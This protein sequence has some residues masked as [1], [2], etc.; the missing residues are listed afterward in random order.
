MPTV[1]HEQQ[2]LSPSSASGAS[3]SAVGAIS[4]LRLVVLGRGGEG[5][6]GLAVSPERRKEEAKLLKRQWVL[7]RK[8]DVQRGRE[9]A[10]RHLLRESGV[11]LGG[12]RIGGREDD[13]KL[14]QQ[15][16]TRIDVPTPRDRG[17]T[18]VAGAATSVQTLPVIITGPP[19][20]DQHGGGA[21][22]TS[23]GSNQQRMKSRSREKK[24]DRSSSRTGSKMSEPESS[25]YAVSFESH[26]ASGSEEEKGGEPVDLREQELKPAFAG[27]NWTDRLLPSLSGCFGGG[28]AVVGSQ[29]A[30]AGGTTPKSQTVS[31]PK[32][33]ER[34]AGLNI[35]QNPSMS[36]S[37]SHSVA[38]QS[39]GY[40]STGVVQLG[41]QQFIYPSI[42]MEGLHQTMGGFFGAGGTG[43]MGTSCS[44][45]SHPSAGVGGNNLFGGSSKRS[46]V[47]GGQTCAGGADHEAA[48]RELVAAEECGEISIPNPVLEVSTLSSNAHL[49]L[50]DEWMAEVSRVGEKVRTSLSKVSKN[51][52]LALAMDRIS[53]SSLSEENVEILQ[54]G[55]H[56]VVG[57]SPER[58]EVQS[59]Q[60]PRA[61]PAGATSHMFLSSS[62]ASDSR[63]HS[64]SA[65]V[66]E[67]QNGG[68][69]FSPPLPWRQAGS[70]QQH[71]KPPSQHS[72][73][74]VSAPQYV[75][76]LPARSPVHYPVA[77]PVLQHADH[78]LDPASDV[79]TLEERDAS[80]GG[81]YSDSNSVSKRRSA[82]REDTKRFGVEESRFPAAEMTAGVSV[83]RVEKEKPSPSP[84]PLSSPA[85]VS[86]VISNVDSAYPKEPPPATPADFAE[87]WTSPSKTAPSSPAKTESLNWPF[88]NHDPLLEAK[89]TGKVKMFL[90]NFS[91]KPKASPYASSTTGTAMTQKE[92]LER[93]LRQY[94]TEVPR[95]VP[96]VVRELLRVFQ[97]EWLV[98]EA[99]EEFEER[100]L[101]PNNGAA[102]E[103]CVWQAEQGDVW[104]DG[105]V[106]VKDKTRTPTKTPELRPAR[107]FVEYGVAAETDGGS[108]EQDVEKVTVK[109]HE[110]DGE[111]G[112]PTTK[113]RKER[114]KE[115]YYQAK[116]ASVV[117]P[118]TQEEKK[119]A[120]A[121]AKARTSGRK[122][123]LGKKKQLPEVSEYVRTQLQ[124]GNG[125]D[126]RVV[127]RL[128]RG[129]YQSPTKLL[130][131]I[132]AQE[133]LAAGGATH[134]DDEDDVVAMG[135]P[136]GPA[137]QEMNV[138]TV[139]GAQSEG[140]LLEDET[141][142]WTS[143]WLSKKVCGRVGLEELNL[144]EEL[145]ESM[146][147]QREGR[148][149]PRVENTYHHIDQD[150]Q[151]LYDARPVQGG[152]GGQ[153]G[154][155]DCHQQQHPSRVK[156]LS[157]FF[158]NKGFVENNGV[159][160]LYADEVG[161]YNSSKYCDLEAGLGARR[162]VSSEAEVDGQH[163]Q[164][165][166]HGSRGGG[167]SSSSSSASQ[168]GHDERSSDE[169]NPESFPFVR[170]VF[171][172]EFSGASDAIRAADVEQ[173]VF[174]CEQNSDEEEHFFQTCAKM[175]SDLYP[176]D[177]YL[178]GQLEEMVH[179]HSNSKSST[180]RCVFPEQLEA[181]E[182]EKQQAHEQV[183]EVI[184]RDEEEF[185]GSTPK[186]DSYLDRE[187][188]F[189]I[190]PP[191]PDLKVSF[192]PSQ[193]G[194]GV[195]PDEITFGERSD[196]EESGGAAAQDEQE[197]EGVFLYSS[198]PKD[199]VRG[200]SGRGRV[201]DASSSDEVE[202][203]GPSE[204]HAVQSLVTELEKT[205]LQQMYSTTGANVARTSNKK[206]AST[207]SNP[208]SAKKFRPSSRKVVGAAPFVS[209][210]GKVY[211]KVA[212]HFVYATS[213]GK[214]VAI[215]GEAATSPKTDAYVPGA[216]MLHVNQPRDTD[217]WSGGQLQK[218]GEG[219]SYGIKRKESPGEQ[220]GRGLYVDTS[221]WT[222]M[223]N[224]EALGEEEAKVRRSHLHGSAETTRRR[225]PNAAKAKAEGENKDAARGARSS[226]DSPKKRAETKGKGKGAVEN[227]KN[228]TPA[229]AD[230]PAAS[231]R[232]GGSSG[233]TTSDKK[234]GPPTKKRSLSQTNRVGS[235]AIKSGSASAASSAKSSKAKAS[236]T[237]PAPAPPP[238]KPAVVKASSSQ[239][240]A[241]SSSRSPNKEAFPN[242]SNADT[243]AA[244]RP[245]IKT[246]TFILGQHIP[247]RVDV[248][249]TRFFEHYPLPFL[250]VTK[251]RENWYF[252]LDVTSGARAQGK[253]VYVDF[254]GPHHVIVKSSR[255]LESLEAFFAS[256]Y[257]KHAQDFRGS[258]QEARHLD[259]GS[260]LLFT[261]Q[262]E[263]S[264][265]PNS[266]SGKRVHEG[267]GLRLY[268][269][270]GSSPGGRGGATALGGEA[271]VAQ[272]QQQQQLDYA[273]MMSGEAMA[274]TG[275]VPGHLSSV[276]FGAKSRE[277]QEA[278]QSLAMG[279]EHVAQSL[280][281]MQ[282]VASQQLMR[283]SA[284][285]SGKAVGE[286]RR[287]AASGSGERLADPYDPSIAGVVRG[288][289]DAWISEKRRTT[290]QEP[291]LG[292]TSRNPQEFSRFPQLEEEKAVSEPRHSLNVSNK[293]S[294]RTH[295]DARQ[296]DYTFAPGFFNRHHESD[297]SARLTPMRVNEHVYGIGLLA[298]PDVERVD[299]MVNG[300][301]HG[302]GVLRPFAESMEQ[303]GSSCGNKVFPRPLNENY[304][305][306]EEKLHPSPEK[307]PLR[308]HKSSR[309]EDYKSS[310]ADPETPNKK[311][312]DGQQSSA[313]NPHL[314]YAE[315]HQR[316]LFYAAARSARLAHTEY[317]ESPPS[318]YRQSGGPRGR[319]LQVP[320]PRENQRADQHA[321]AVLSSR[322]NAHEEVVADPSTSSRKN[323][324]EVGGEV[325]STTARKNSHEA[326]TASSSA[327]YSYTQAYF[328]RQ[329]TSSDL[330]EKTQSSKVGT[331][332]A[333]VNQSTNSSSSRSQSAHA[334]S[335]VV[336]KR[337]PFCAG[338]NYGGAMVFS[339]DP[340]IGTN[341]TRKEVFSKDPGNTQKKS[342]TGGGSASSSREGSKRAPAPQ[343]APPVP[344][345]PRSESELLRASAETG[346]LLASD[347]LWRAERD[348]NPR[349]GARQ[350]EGAHARPPRR[351]ENIHTKFSPDQERMIVQE[352]LF[353]S[354]GMIR[355]QQE[356]AT[357]AAEAANFGR[358]GEVQ[359]FTHGQSSAGD[360]NTI[361]GPA[362]M[363]N[364]PGSG[365]ISEKKLSKAPKAD[366]RGRVGSPGEIFRQINVQ[367]RLRKQRSASPPCKNFPFRIKDTTTFRA[368][369]T[370]Q[371][372]LIS[373]ERGSPASRR[374]HP[375]QQQELNATS[376]HLHRRAQA[377]DEAFSQ[378]IGL[379]MKEAARKAEQY[380]QDFQSGRPNSPEEQHLNRMLGV[381]VI[382]PMF[383]PGGTTVSS[384]RLNKNNSK[385]S[386]STDGRLSVSQANN[387]KNSCAPPVDEYA[388][389][390]TS[391][392]YRQY[393]ALR[394]RPELQLKKMHSIRRIS[395]NGSLVAFGF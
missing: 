243:K 359:A 143:T 52:T 226:S 336:D 287:G 276:L 314:F 41:P 264:L 274:G 174:D 259:Y 253:K 60:Q 15:A 192:R 256:V 17:R 221:N 321:D 292:P 61:S 240:K 332:A 82:S 65:A 105:A 383:P 312:A 307:Q 160:H 84:P 377:D 180:Y 268:P 197:H 53:K 328:S 27:K 391:E 150:Q 319:K 31:S 204:Q 298:G 224:G 95:A 26:S 317:F 64:V 39:V 279:S 13:A 78:D 32:L 248:A 133:L 132:N 313:T 151:F 104:E 343:P 177:Y 371:S 219:G 9:D 327:R 362:I 217:Y 373:G 18:E 190:S 135:S 171:P 366:F 37:A 257:S 234:E 293:N 164:H 322:K 278:I 273:T 251:L 111:Q 130:L 101:H 46:V 239:G 43:T 58:S 196:V 163:G 91:S 382:D 146:R 47:S 54:E 24:R 315:E 218:A 187:I 340:A 2:Q 34:P 129:H 352:L 194:L 176:D 324:H 388:Q 147:A 198:D 215:S 179:D 272:S 23:P 375:Q 158:E 374:H 205:Q 38:T 22:A 271:L 88:T 348:E 131:D 144:V 109:D 7:Q 246:A 208:S 99:M 67:L 252:V 212:N 167:G 69:F 127:E 247:D 72:H 237:A 270:S 92:A 12:S 155:E 360:T 19:L 103:N 11:E 157:K 40:G 51:N 21:N 35:F 334:Q 115:Y 152:K 342:T 73:G 300:E 381:H 125:I 89:I 238:R 6:A 98:A 77:V 258:L 33:V 354:R 128:A 75:R 166:P 30:G 50:G 363:S 8:E 223:K 356:A 311:V 86:D 148:H 102:Q 228:K 200:T 168:G 62:Q 326:N 161:C 122:K 346:K 116:M 316:N 351:A 275:V 96:E 225:G 385:A 112:S 372:P 71:S 269:G 353:G 394:P 120:K 308:P 201:V 318:P 142:R 153:Q 358:D 355:P 393:C 165:G 288:P 378:S 255:G 290:G 329:R 182:E 114:V 365:E 284:S 389:S 113:R 260:R 277:D 184:R 123:V 185:F 170:A 199:D 227:A 169:E 220:G 320:H 347:Q 172:E 25:E 97:V 136:D 250:Q 286:R 181:S 137:V 76:A 4:P 45:D 66:H 309:A 207:S 206:M 134:Q 119:Q 156:E 232:R 149:Y 305:D 10:T 261:Q 138:N 48:Q 93:L 173:D 68:G 289:Q 145:G 186:S 392:V 245:P 117:R 283:A 296:F 357:S 369:P 236:R 203:V 267:M 364:F 56:E 233:G 63:S 42:Q 281:S 395:A 390:R 263:R 294:T 241:E 5:G 266:P 81:R 85:A 350:N 349:N 345:P 235:I 16:W 154:D 333:G 254:R 291:I 140:D 265:S 299:V 178:R 55:D 80:V 139:G 282:E 331:T 285:A 83:V 188:S 108:Q 3:G 121:K 49:D 230:K 280:K 118:Q 376:S 213:Y 141:F 183:L 249:L 386:S 295:M 209:N 107:I 210:E 367:H 162:F 344:V 214:K 202:R 36:M 303:E 1:N 28:A 222:V 231:N 310:R 262:E 74:S 361:S 330:G 297:T 14:L 301:L 100:C 339:T 20:P 384:D 229:A 175:N 79:N 57:P 191:V 87:E 379:A 244:E 90:S 335:L 94:A 211:Q 337:A 387:S 325:C 70:D 106:V 189:E 302:T 370:A 124:Q 195:D 44:S 126:G 242:K 341:Y 338:R 59:H 216:S 193:E 323:S 304:Y 368:P 110:E 29:Q 159:S 306:D 380:H